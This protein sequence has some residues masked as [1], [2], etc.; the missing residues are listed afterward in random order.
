MT[1]IA[2]LA[3]L[4]SL[5]RTPDIHGDIWDPSS[6]FLQIIQRLD[7]IYQNIPERYHLNDLNMYILKDNHLLGA[8]FFF[9]L[10][11]H[12]VVFDLTRISLAGFNFPLAA[13]FQR[14]PPEF[15]L[16]C[17][18]RCRF[19]A[20]QV[21]DLIRRGMLHGRA[22]FDD[23]FCADAALESAKIQIIYAATVNRA[24][25]VVGTTRENLKT[26]FEFL[27]MFNRGKDAPSPFVRHSILSKQPMT[28]S[29]RSVLY[30]RFVCYLA[31]VI[32]PKKT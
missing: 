32:S 25:E 22:A 6:P 13:A 15:R 26:H 28:D 11:V 9:Y 12:A 23:M 19:H 18:D 21:S 8:T 29:D 4:C 3:D 17:Q 5:I 24:T 7:A 14:A 30:C 20:E 2:F 1:S 10:L 16:Q 27:E 31:F